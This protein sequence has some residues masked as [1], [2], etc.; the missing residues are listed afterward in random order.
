MRSSLNFWRGPL[1]ATLCLSLGACSLFGSKDD[2]DK[3]A[4]LVE[5][6]TTVKVQKVWSAKLGGNAEGLRLG[7]VPATN[8]ARVFAASSAGE[9]VAFDAVSG[10][11]VWRKQTELPLSG[12]PGVGRDRI[13]VGSSEGDLAVL[14]I[15]SGEM[16]WQIKIGSEILAAPALSVDSV[17]VRTG[18]GRLVAFD[19]QS[20]EQQ[21]EI[22]KIVQGLTLRGNA[23]PVISGPLVVAGFDDGTLAAVNLADGNIVW[24]RATSERRGRTEFD[25]LADVDG[26]VAVVGED[27]FAAG[28]QGTAALLSLGSGSPVWRQDLSSH[29]ALAVDWNRVYITRED[30]AVI[31]L[32]RSTGVIMWEQ[33]AL[34][35]RGITGPAVSGS[36]VA[37]GDF[38]GYVHFMDAASGEFVARVR[39]G[40]GPIV[41]APM[42][43]A[44]VVYTLNT[45]GTLTALRP[46]QPAP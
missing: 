45:D 2:E 44:D 43:V 21:W 6:T 20:G 26:R 9:V 36:V 25:R 34:S 30:D 10:D 15:D 46:A 4:E 42:V 38:E 28:F 33:S 11:R 1:L 40:G 37:V 12:G 32:N 5:F 39:V 8:G 24:E 29:E 35:R 18:D 14:A 7:L 16:L 17:V 22:Q 27:V 19:A 41:A 13:A 3:P 31:A 23:V